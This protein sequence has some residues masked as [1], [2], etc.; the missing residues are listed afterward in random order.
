MQ[1]TSAVTFNLEK[2]T[3]DSTVYT[4]SYD[5]YG[6]ADTGKIGNTIVSNFEYCNADKIV[7]EKR[8]EYRP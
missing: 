2:I 6:N 4:F 5:V 3:T 1:C 7:S 8:T